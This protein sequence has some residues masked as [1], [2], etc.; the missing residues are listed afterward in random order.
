MY[1]TASGELMQVKQCSVY[2]LT[3]GESDDVF[4]QSKAL[5]TFN[6]TGVVLN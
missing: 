6:D 2:W 4:S 1:A 5:A 3:R